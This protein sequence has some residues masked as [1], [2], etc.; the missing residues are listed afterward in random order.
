MISNQYPW[1]VVVI[2]TISL[3]G[4]VFLGYYM[5]FG[6]A[7]EGV[8]LEEQSGRVV[9]TD[10]TEETAGAR[11]GI[12]SGD[13]V[14]SVNGHQIATIVDWMAHRMNFEAGR[15]TAIRTMRPDT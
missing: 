10:V 2:A 14:I 15:P 9:V 12:Q 1:R 3:I 8:S 7:S 6:L 4:N 13:Q 11:A 5:L